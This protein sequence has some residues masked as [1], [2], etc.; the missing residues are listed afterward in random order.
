MVA[1]LSSKCLVLSLIFGEGSV[2]VYR[3][4]RMTKNSIPLEW[5]RYTAV[6]APILKIVTLAVK[7]YKCEGILR[8]IQ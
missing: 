1:R 4:Q 5:M 3:Q 7:T 8:D 6:L 2:R